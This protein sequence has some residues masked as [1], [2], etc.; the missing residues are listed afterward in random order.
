MHFRWSSYNSHRLITAGLSTLIICLINAA[1][2]MAS[3]GGL[4][5]RARLSLRCRERLLAIRLS[6]GVCRCS[7][8]D[9]LLLVCRISCTRPRFDG[10][11][12]SAVVC[13]SACLP[14]AQLV[15][16]VSYLSRDETALH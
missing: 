3:N 14:V 2:P 4:D 11:D 5:T 1:C 16:L 8:A 6:S 9:M 13:M 7:S 10:R 15:P 12:R